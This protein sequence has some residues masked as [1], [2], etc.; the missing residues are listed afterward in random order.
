MQPIEIMKRKRVLDYLSHV[1]N[2]RYSAHELKEQIE[3][4]RENL[5]D[6]PESA[7]SRMNNYA[8]ALERVLRDAKTAQDTFQSLSEPLYRY[9]MIEYYIKGKPLGQVARELGIE[10]QAAIDARF[11]AMLELRELVPRSFRSF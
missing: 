3:E 4:M 7:T 9:C 5:K 8:E 6:A 2:L 1:E 10:K 11:C